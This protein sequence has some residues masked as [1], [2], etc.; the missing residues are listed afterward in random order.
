M[1]DLLSQVSKYDSQLALIEQ[2]KELQRATSKTNGCRQESGK[3]CRDHET[4]SMERRKRKRHEDTVDTSLYLK[5]HKILSYFFGPLS[6][7]FLFV[8]IVHHFIPCLSMFCTRILLVIIR[9]F[10]SST[11]KQNKGA[12]ADGLL[13][14]DDSHGQGMDMVIIFK[15]FAGVNKESYLLLYLSKFYIKLRCHVT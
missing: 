6:I 1:K 15:L 10:L 2:E 11:D 8:G 7:Y 9:L 14:D 4:I 3:N 5:K 13:I 12:D